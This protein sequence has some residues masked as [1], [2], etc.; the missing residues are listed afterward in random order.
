MRELLVATQN[1]GKL[2]EVRQ[3]LSSLAVAWCS[4]EPEW[5]AALPEE[6][7]DYEANARAKAKSAAAASGRLTVADD[8][9]LE[10]DALGGA[11]GPFSARFGGPHLDAAGRNTHLLAQLEGV[12]DARRGARFVCIAAVATPSGDCRVARGEC[13]GSILRAPRGVA[14]F[15]YDPLFWVADQGRAMAEL[16]EDEKHALSHRGRAFRG[17]RREIEALLGP[18]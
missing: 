14:G 17:L 5:A 4:L 10:V 9:G 6:G 16:S 7:S 18:G 13:A 1:P 11:P 3:I 12:P 15:G 8:S 2:R